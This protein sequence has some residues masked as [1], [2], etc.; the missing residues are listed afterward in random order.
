MERSAKLS[1]QNLMLQKMNKSLY[2]LLTLLVS[3]LTASTSLAEP[4]MSFPQGLWV[5]EYT[6]R[7]QT[8]PLMIEFDTADKPS[9]VSYLIKRKQNAAKPAKFHA[10]VERTTNKKG[11]DII[12][13]KPRYWLNN[14]G[15]TSMLK[16]RGKYSAETLE[17]NIKKKGCKKFRVQKLPCEKIPE[18]CSETALGPLHALMGN[19]KVAAKPKAPKAPKTPASA[20]SAIQAQNHLDRL[21]LGEHQFKSLLKQLKDQPFQKGQVVVLSRWIQQ[22]KM[23]SQQ[24]A[25]IIKMQ[26]FQSDRLEVLR[27]LAG[28]VSDTENINL[29]LDVIRFREERKAA[30]KI[31]FERNPKNNQAIRHY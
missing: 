15:Q 16:L 17:G 12:V 7:G 1:A 5:G 30:E 10:N 19:G 8:M 6:C 20:T 11:E 18:A 25:T 2:I 27:V 23:T 3:M 31:I 26:R 14:P 13:F 29:V 22:Y 4:E 21:P 24:V 28:S 9:S